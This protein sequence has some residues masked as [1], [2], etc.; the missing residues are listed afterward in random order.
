VR[1]IHSRGKVPLRLTTTN[2]AEEAAEVYSKHDLVLNVPLN[3]D[4]NLRFLET[5]AA[6]VPQVVYGESRTAWY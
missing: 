5:M 4:L 2:I 3:H 6:G 1:K